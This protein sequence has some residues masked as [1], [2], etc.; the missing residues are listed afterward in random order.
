MTRSVMKE[1]E[2]RGEPVV[3]SFTHQGR[4]VR[5]S[6]THCVDKEGPATDGLYGYYY[7]YH[8]YQFTQGPESLRVRSYRDQPEEAHFLGIERDG[9]YRLL[10][11]IDVRGPLSKAAQAYLRMAGKRNLT[12]LDPNNDTSGYSPLPSAPGEPAA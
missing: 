8:V 3:D 1:I 7:E 6:R 12:W 2:E 10:T 4:E 11:E 9:R 5:V